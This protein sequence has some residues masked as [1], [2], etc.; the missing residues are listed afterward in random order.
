M[1]LILSRTILGVEHGDERAFGERQRSIQGFRLGARARIGRDQD[2]ERRTEI[3]LQQGISGCHIMRLEDEN[4]LLFFNWV[5]QL[6]QR[7]DKVRPPR[8]PRRRARPR[9]CRSAGRS[10]RRR[11]TRHARQRVAAPMTRSAAHARK[12]S[13]SAALTSAQA[14]PRNTAEAPTAAAMPPSHAERMRGG[15]CAAERSGPFS[16]Q[17]FR[18]ALTQ[19]R[20]SMLQRKPLEALW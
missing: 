16:P 12:I 18:C 19:G 7:R 9:W 6:A 8:S 3:E 10:V 17:R 1:Q 13:A 20:C 2:F 14:T 11:R 15:H 4:H 5:I